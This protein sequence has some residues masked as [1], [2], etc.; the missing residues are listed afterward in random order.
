MISSEEVPLELMKKLRNLFEA[1]KDKKV[2]K[3]FKSII[4]DL[5]YYKF[6]QSLCDMIGELTQ[7]NSEFFMTKIFQKLYTE[8]IEKWGI[9]EQYAKY[10]NEINL[11]ILVKYCLF[12]GEQILIQFPAQV[13]PLRVG[14]WLY[15]TNF[16]MALIG[17]PVQVN[18]SY[19]TYMPFKFLLLIGAGIKGAIDSQRKAIR[20][21]IASTLSKDLSDFQNGEFGYTLPVVNAYDIRKT[22]KEFSYMI[23]LEPEKIEFK[24]R[25]SFRDPTEIYNQIENLLQK[26]Q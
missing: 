20:R 12:E 26:Y 3:T 9:A 11:Y 1:Q 7:M 16:R 17:L 22:Q 25:T 2:L 19:V 6:P 10:I 14:G 21:K 18:M 8:I 24:I 15:L 4:Y 23:D 13:L 5:A